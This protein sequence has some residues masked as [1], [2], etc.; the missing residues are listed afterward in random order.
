MNRLLK[1][2]MGLEKP[3]GMSTDGSMTTYK[4]KKSLHGHL[5]VIFLDDG[6]A[7]RAATRRDVTVERARDSGR[8]LARIRLLVTKTP[9]PYPNRAATRFNSGAASRSTSPEL[10]RE[11]RSTVAVAPQVPYS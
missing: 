1:R 9:T 7:S 11:N 8:G 6:R 3:T 10:R 2:M 4:M 5:D